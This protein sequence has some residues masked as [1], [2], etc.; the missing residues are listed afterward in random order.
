V[1]REEVI[2]NELDALAESAADPTPRLPV[3]LAQRVLERNDRVALAELRLH[4]TGLVSL[5]RA[6][7]V[8]G[9]IEPVTLPEE[10]HEATK[11][12]IYVGRQER[13]YRTPAFTAITDLLYRAASPAP[14]CCSASTA[15][16]MACASVPAASHAT[17]RYR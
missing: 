17:Q 15:R 6:R 10:R 11:L 13:V 3:L 1:G 12:T 7:L 5:E 4:D 2:A 14:P 16:P 9:D 8:S